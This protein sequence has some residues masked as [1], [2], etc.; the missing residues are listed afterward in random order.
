M[1]RRQ[2]LGSGILLSGALAAAPLATMSRRAQSS[3]AKPDFS[4]IDGWINGEPMSLASL[5]GSVV[6][7]N[8][9]TY[10]CINS[11]R[12]MVYLKRWHDAYGPQGLRVVGIHTPEFRFEHDR[13]NVE[14]YIRQEGLRFPV[15]LDN[16]YATWN[17]FNNEAWPAFY[18]IDRSGRVVL[19][20]E[21]ED[22]AHEMERAIRRTLGLAVVEP[23]GQPEDDPD[24][25]RVGTPE[26]YFGAQ[27]P[28]P[29]D[30]RQSPRLGTATYAFPGESGPKPNEYLL[31]GSWARQDERLSLASTHGALRFRYSAAKLYMVAGSAHPA[32]LRVRVDGT[33]RPPVE[34]GWPTLYTIVNG[35]TYD[36]HLLELETDT[37]GLTFYSATF[38]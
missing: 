24:L 15:G 3:Q 19:I 23:V 17:A 36:E 31:D 9:W 32:T 8:F 16:A 6:L 37:P 28:T 34:I 7:V 35:N 10:S 26:T 21:G 30:I 12:P 27:H 29:Q 22:H 5:R 14:T 38:G 33:E 20:R 25:S 18:L 2:L 13:S 1:M 4:G 11:R